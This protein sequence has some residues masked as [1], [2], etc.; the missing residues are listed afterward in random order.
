VVVKESK[1]KLSIKKR[2][3]VLGVNRSSY[4][5]WLNTKPKEIDENAETEINNIYHKHKGT[6]GRIRITQAM[7]NSG[8]TINHKKVYSIMRKLGLKAVIRK[9]W[10]TRKYI[11]ENVANNILNREFKTSEP[12]KKLVCDVTEL[13]RIND[14]RYYLFSI[15][16]LYSNAVIASNVSFHNDW[17]LVA[18]GLEKLPEQAKKIILH[19]DQGSQFTSLLYR[20]IAEQKNITL[21]MSRVGNCYDNAAKESFFGHFKE[22]F[23]IYYNPRTQEELYQNIAAFIYYYNNDRI[24]MRFKMSPM[25]YMKS[26]NFSLG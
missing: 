17:G 8:I 21:S 25:Q 5:K 15:M 2:C 19:S 18:K 22:E 23:Y 24:Q 6:Y 3:Y 13:K 7:R 26:H 16:D 20:K 10:C 4:Y 9:K 11:K 1:A 14:K 12:L